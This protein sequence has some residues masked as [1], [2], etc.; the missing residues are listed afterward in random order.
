MCSSDFFLFKKYLYFNSNIRDHILYVYVFLRFDGLYLHTI[1]WCFL[2]CLCRRNMKIYL[3][4]IIYLPWVL[5]SV[6]NFFFFFFYRIAYSKI[7]TGN[8]RNF[9]FF[10]YFPT[11]SAGYRR[12]DK[13]FFFFHHLFLIRNY[14]QFLLCWRTV[15]HSEF[16]ITTPCLRHHIIS[17]KIRL[18]LS[19][20]FILIYS[21]EERFFFSTIG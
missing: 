1:R 16:N 18:D 11:I 8:N 7:S 14:L 6:V 2:L 10:P 5:Y 19:I 17:P 20:Y 3:K 9:G 12:F 15:E 13:S 4:N 21:V